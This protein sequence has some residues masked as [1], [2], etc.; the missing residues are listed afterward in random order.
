MTHFAERRLAHFGLPTH[1]G[2]DVVQQALYAILKAQQGDGGRNPNPEDLESQAA[3]VNYLR[4]VVNSIAEGWARP[5]F[6]NPHLSLD[7]VQ[8]VVADPQVSQVEFRDLMVQ[9]FVRMRER[10]PARLFPTIDAWEKSPD[11]RIP[12]VT[13]RKHVSAVREIARDILTKLGY[14]PQDEKPPGRLPSGL[15]DSAHFESAHPAEALDAASPE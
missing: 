15:V 4:G 5:L 1:Q 11:G 3:F 10:A 6:R 8:E 2:E 13:C 9:M 7:A 14:M 12:C